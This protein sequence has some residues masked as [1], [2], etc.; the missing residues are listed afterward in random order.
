[1]FCD[2]LSAD[3]K[4]RAIQ[5][6]S[7]CAQV[8]PDI[9]CRLTSE[10]LPQ[11]IE[12]TAWHRHAPQVRE[13]F[14]AWSEALETGAP[15]ALAPAQLADALALARQIQLGALAVKPMPDPANAHAA[16][17]L[18]WS[19]DGAATVALV[20]RNHLQI[21]V[22]AVLGDAGMTLLADDIAAED[23]MIAQV[24]GLVRQRLRS[25]G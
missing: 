8:L 21:L 9:L 11:V 17:D 6:Q 22:V 1:M 14:T 5:A 15:A 16:P 7:A 18:A 3:Q 2:G 19:G 12:M 20:M 23:R 25:L 10:L 4:L 24:Q 13:R